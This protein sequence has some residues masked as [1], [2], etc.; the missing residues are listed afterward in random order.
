MGQLRELESLLTQVSAPAQITSAQNDAVTMWQTLVPKAWVQS[1]PSADF[2]NIRDMLKN[3]EKA[4]GAKQ[5]PQAE[6]A[7]LEGYAILDAGPEIRLRGLA[8][9]L[10][11]ELS[12]LFWQGFEGTPGLVSLIAAQADVAQ[13]RA[14]SAKINE[15]LIRAQAIGGQRARLARG[16]DWQC[17]GDY[18]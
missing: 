6:S 13:V 2:D 11:N 16:R 14:T 1:N 4:V 8:P 5:Y 12:G 17:G 9:E 7:R 15:A 3:V 18:F 10:A